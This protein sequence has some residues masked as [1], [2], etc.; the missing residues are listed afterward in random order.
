VKILTSKLFDIKILP[1]LFADPAPVK[2][3]RK[4]GG[5]GGYPRKHKFSWNETASGATFACNSQV[6]FREISTKAFRRLAMEVGD[7]IPYQLDGD[8][9]NQEAEDL[10]DGSDRARPQ[11]PHQRP[12]QPEK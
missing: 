4:V 9:E 2:A 5:E 7:A 8:G 10:V 12:S 3:F 11:P 1:T 6:F